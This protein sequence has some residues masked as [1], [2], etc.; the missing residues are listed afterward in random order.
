[1][2]KGKIFVLWLQGIQEAPDLVKICVN[3]IL[4]NCNGHEV[5]LLNENNITDWI[6][7]IPSEID[8]K[9]KKGIFPIQLKSDYIRLALLEKYNCL[10]LDSTIFVSQP[11]DDSIFKQDFYTVIRKEEK[12]SDLT[13]KISTFVLGGNNSLRSQSLFSF[14][15]RIFSEYLLSEDELI[16]YFLIENIFSIAIKNTKWLRDDIYQYDI[17]KKNILGLVKKMNSAIDKNEYKKFIQNNTFNKLNHRI[18]YS[19]FD[20]TG[21]ETY[22]NHLLKEYNNVF[23]NNASL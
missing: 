22:Y 5:V 16:N 21:K 6:D 14:V 19:L 4:R 2:K 23:N 12:H 7:P 13:N 9:F 10:W 20:K 8:K 15:K 11:I 3:S 18:E 1:M 17:N